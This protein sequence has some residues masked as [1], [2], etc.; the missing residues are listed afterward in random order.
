MNILDCPPTD[1]VRGRI[2]L[3]LLK[4]LPKINGCRV[5]EIGSRRTQPDA[6]RDLRNF[7]AS[8]NYTGFDLQEGPG[9]DEVHDFDEDEAIFFEHK[10]NA[11]ICS[12]VLEHV[13]RPVRFLRNVGRLLEP[14]SL[15]IVTTLF[16]FPLHGYPNDY[17]R[18]SE[19]GLR[20]VLDDAGFDVF[21][22]SS[23]GETHFRLSDH[24]EPPCVKAAP[25]HTFALAC[26][27]GP[28]WL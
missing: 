6:W 12:E 27:I 7:V 13:K 1:S 9:V 18:F 25:I 3:W 8:S 5:A 10:F 22:T 16:A 2:L 15:L 20:L 28:R 11:A 21:E 24:G 26:W 4:H 19:A 23:A 14:G 17:W